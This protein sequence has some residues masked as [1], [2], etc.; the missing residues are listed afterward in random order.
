[1]TTTTLPRA[2]GRMRHRGKLSVLSGPDQGKQHEFEGRVRIGSR[3]YA[4]VVLTDPGVSGVHCELITGEELRVRDLGSKNGTYIR[5]VRVIEAALSPGEVL[6][7]GTSRVQVAPLEDV[8]EMPAAGEHTLHGL[9]GRSATMQALIA[10]IE[11]VGPSE[12]TV[13]LQ[14]ET[15]T[16][17]ERAAEA[18]HLASKRAGKPLITVD[19]GAMPATLIDAE[20][21]GYERGAFTGADRSFA[22]AFER[23]QGGTVFLDEI[24][25]LPLSLQPKLLRVL[26]SREVRRLGGLKVIPVDL[27]VIAATHRDLPLEVS[28]GRFREDLYYRLAVVTLTMPPLRDRVEDLPLLIVHLLEQMGADPS[29]FLTVEG[30]QTLAGHPWPGNVRELRNTLERA[31]T[32]AEPPEL[33]PV[34]PTSQV[35]LDFSVPLTVGKKRLGEIYERQYLTHMIA[36]CEDNIA[37]VARRSGLERM[38]VYR[39]LRRLGLRDG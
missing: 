33:E 17:K 19:C 20:L 28:S 13:L 5:G 29:P 7:L 31:S 8:V 3:A 37:E 16:G 1:M 30:L 25:E 21:F 15:G 2:G 12:S 24:G 9:V 23:A 14:G 36:E 32:L 38:S 22:G 18:L 34:T 4:D 35:E 11:A 26:E 6:T 39:I 10:R 27:R